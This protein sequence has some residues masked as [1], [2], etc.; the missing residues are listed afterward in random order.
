VTDALE[1]IAG[2]Y[3]LQLS[4]DKDVNLSGLRITTIFKKESVSQMLDILLF[5]SRCRY[6]IKGNTLE[7][8]KK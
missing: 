2:R 3:N 6:T 1:R 7:I 5:V 8:V 4:Y